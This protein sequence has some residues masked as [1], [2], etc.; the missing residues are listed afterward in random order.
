MKK[1]KHLLLTMML[2]VFMVQP[3]MANVLNND[4]MAFAFA[5]TPASSDFGEM[6]L[7]SHQEMVET[8][9]DLFW[10]VLPLARVA[11]WTLPRILPAYKAIRNAKTAHTILLKSGVHRVQIGTSRLGRHV[12]LGANASNQARAKWHIYQSKPWRIN[13]F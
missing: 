4:D 13:P 11:I 8:E 1:L 10:F 7:L 12:G 2:A 3:A 9:G 6:A 5:G